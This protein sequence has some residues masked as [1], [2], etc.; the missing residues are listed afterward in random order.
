[1][2]PRGAC[3]SHC[4]VAAG[5][6]PFRWLLGVG[7]AVDVADGR[8]VHPCHYRPLVQFVKAW[9]YW[10]ESR[11]DV[12]DGPSPPG[13]DPFHLANVAAIVR[14]LPPVTASTCPPAWTS[15]GPRHRG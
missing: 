1:M 8:A 14:S 5:L 7:F 13:A 12:F 15:T 4:C 3:A 10:V 9:T 6:V 11:C 2:A